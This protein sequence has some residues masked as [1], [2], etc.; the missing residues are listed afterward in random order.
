MDGPDSD[1]NLASIWCARGEQFEQCEEGSFKSSRKVP[2]ALLGQCP[3][4]EIVRTCSALESYPTTEDAVRLVETAR[5]NTHGAYLNGYFWISA[6]L[7]SDNLSQSIMLMRILNLMVFVLVILIVFLVAGPELR[8]I[9]SLAL[10]VSIPAIAWLVVPISNQSWMVTGLMGYWVFFLV[11]GLKRD[12]DL[13]HRILAGSG[14]ALCI[15]LTFLSRTDAVGLL[16]AETAICAAIVMKDRGKPLWQLVAAGFSVGF[17]GVLILRFVISPGFFTSFLGVFRGE[18]GSVRKYDFSFNELVFHNIHHVTEFVA[19]SLTG[20]HVTS[21]D[22]LAPGPTTF[23]ILLALGGLA[24]FLAGKP[25][26]IFIVVSSFILVILVAYPILATV[27]F[28]QTFIQ[29]FAPRYLSPFAIPA[30]GLLVLTSP[31]S[32][33]LNSLP[34]SIRRLLVILVG[35][36]H[37]SALHIVLRSAVSGDN[38]GISTWN[39]NDWVLW[40]WPVGPSPM[41]VW[42]LGSAALPIFLS[43]E[44]S[45]ASNA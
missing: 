39:L 21:A 22:P 11:L 5:V 33:R 32:D 42:L 41:T 14:L 3:L 15:G 4:S 12:L 38:L 7:V 34:A 6:V 40:W 27:R 36:A 16:A 30:I 25:S 28:G 8:R 2:I 19:S 10:A 1:F 17:I 23:L 20:S 26:Q 37:A 13:L 9:F 29:E 24:F 44:L 35:L 43:R 31:G 45:R 18:T